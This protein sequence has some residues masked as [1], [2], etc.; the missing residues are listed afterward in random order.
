MNPETALTITLSRT[1]Q[2]IAAL[3]LVAFS[4]AA[5]PATLN[6]NPDNTDPSTSK[7]LYNGTLSSNVPCI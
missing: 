7:V 6:P 5:A 4:I 3:T 1:K 2:L